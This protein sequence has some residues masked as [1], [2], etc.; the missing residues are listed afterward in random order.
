LG[1]PPKAEKIG[2]N[3]SENLEVSSLTKKQKI[4]CQTL[5]DFAHCANELAA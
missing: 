5:F 4:S 2:A 3:F 1:T